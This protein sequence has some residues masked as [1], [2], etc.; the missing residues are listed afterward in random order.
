MLRDPRSKEHD[1]NSRWTT[2]VTYLSP[3][4]FQTRSGTGFF[5]FILWRRNCLTWRWL[6]F[7]LFYLAQTYT[8]TR[9]F[10]YPFKG[11]VALVWVWLQVVWLERAKIGEELLSFLTHQARRRRIRPLKSSF[12]QCY[13]FR[14]K[15]DHID[16]KFF[17][18]P[19]NTVK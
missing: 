1:N 4:T 10:N 13:K 11:T 9:S 6:L 5:G 3:A 19:T 7:I 15:N 2:A 17:V 16:L 18:S 12:F 14:S 8:E